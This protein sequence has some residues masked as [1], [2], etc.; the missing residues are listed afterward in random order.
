[1]VTQ[2][3]DYIWL[4][5]ISLPFLCQVSHNDN[6][7]CVVSKFLNIYFATYWKYDVQDTGDI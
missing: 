5:K 3:I 2:F 6:L 7:E 1:M 4:H